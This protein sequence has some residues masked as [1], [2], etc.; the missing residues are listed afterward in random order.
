M[1]WYRHCS[2]LSKDKN[3]KHKKIRN[4]G[5]AFRDRLRVLSRGG[6]G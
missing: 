4:L 5:K 3:E 1:K 2:L 6:L